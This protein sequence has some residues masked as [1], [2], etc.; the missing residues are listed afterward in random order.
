MTIRPWLKRIL[1]AL[2]TAAAVVLGVLIQLVLVGLLC[3]LL[4][5]QIAVAVFLL[6]PLLLASAATSSTS[7]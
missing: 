5:F 2:L 1:A 7:E 3:S 6:S 4:P